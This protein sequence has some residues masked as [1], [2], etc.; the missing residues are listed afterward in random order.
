MGLGTAEKGMVAWM[1]SKEEMNRAYQQLATKFQ[2][3]AIERN[4]YM[5][6][7]QQLSNQITINA[8]RHANEVMRLRRRLARR[9]RSWWRAAKLRLA[10]MFRRRHVE[11]ECR[12]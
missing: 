7:C 8:K 9:R 1:S 5:A 11:M 12:P 6:G 10:G 3:A 2:Q 4:A